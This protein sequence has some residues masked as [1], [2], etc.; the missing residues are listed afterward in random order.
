MSH[1]PSKLTI[2]FILTFFANQTNA[3]IWKKIT[4]GAKDIQDAARQVTNTTKE[5]ANTVKAAKELKKAGRKTLQVI[6]VTIRYL[7]TEIEKK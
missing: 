6:S 5:V 1:L 7:I 3:Q 4:E 2:L